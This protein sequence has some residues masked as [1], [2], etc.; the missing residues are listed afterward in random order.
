MPMMSRAP[1]FGALLFVITLAGGCWPNVVAMG[2]DDGDAHCVDHRQDEDETDID[3]GGATCRGCFG[4][5]LCFSDFDCATGFCSDG[6]CGY[7]R[8]CAELQERTA[9]VDGVV[10]VDFDGD[11]P[12]AP[13]QVLCDQSSDAGGWMLAFKVNP[14]VHLDVPERREQLS[15]RFNP[16]LLVDAALVDD[17]GLASHGAAALTATLAFRPSW[18]R[19]TLVAASDDT[20]RVTWFKRV[21]SPQS[22][23]RWFDDD[24]LASPVCPAPTESAECRE[25]TIATN[26][27][28]TWLHG[29]SLQ[30]FGFEAGED[31]FLRLDGM[32]PDKYVEVGGVCSGSIGDNGWQ[33]DAPERCGNGMLI[34]LR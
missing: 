33:D 10:W 12:G 3:C 4:G 22:F 6:E 8:S 18:A 20:Q 17:R 26:G 23:A 1:G 9:A 28:A 2:D 15:G 31:L 30:D 27:D 5:E 11:G 16:N 34:W 21:A 24:G 13:T 7:L 32:R 14:T 29:F 19:V 25:G